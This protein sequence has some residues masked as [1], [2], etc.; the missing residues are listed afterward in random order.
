MD[1]VG[2]GGDFGG[3]GFGSGHDFGGGHHSGHDFG[4]GHHGGHDGGQHDGGHQG[5]E[6]VNN[7]TV[8][9]AGYGGYGYGFGYDGFTLGFT[10]GLLLSTLYLPL[11]GGLYSPW[12]M[13]TASDGL[14]VAL[15]AF[16]CL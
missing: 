16:D 10:E 12:Y 14:C 1:G 13:Q 15:S 8:V 11:L 3:G 9:E 6:T 5:G 2:G 4:G 7:I